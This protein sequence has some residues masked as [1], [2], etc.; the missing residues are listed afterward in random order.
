MNITPINTMPQTLPISYSNENATKVVK[1]NTP[2]TPSTENVKNVQNTSIPSVGQLDKAIEKVKT[3]VE[4]F[5]NNIEYSVNKDTD[6]VVVKIIDKSTK[7]VLRQIPS[8]EMLALAEQL[9]KIT[10]LFLKQKA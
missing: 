6:Q 3:Y 7:E 10:G 9:D 4:S 8:E 1:T 5:N 2:S